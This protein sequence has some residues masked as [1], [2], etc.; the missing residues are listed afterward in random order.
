MTILGIETS[1]DETSAS[2]LRITDG[3]IEVLSNV[4]SS[5]IKLHAPFGG[6]VPALAAREHSQNLRPVVTEALS[7]AQ[8]EKPDLIAVT[9]G[10]GLISSLLVGS[11]FAQTLAWKYNIPI[12]GVNHMEGHVYSNWFSLSSLTEDVFPVVCLVVSGGHTQLILMKNHGEYE[13]LGQTRDD[14]AGEAFDKIARILG[15]G[16]PGGPALSKEAEKYNPEDTTD[17]ELPRPMI[18]SGNFEFSFSGLKTSVLYLIRDLQKAEKNIGQLA[19][20][21]AHEAQNA[22]VETLVT[23]TMKAALGHNAKTI[24][25]AGG[26]SAN[27]LLREELAKKAEQK[28]IAYVQPKME[29]TTDNAAMIALAGYFNYQKNPS[30]EWREVKANANW[31][32]V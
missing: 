17:I 32:I 16:Y 15:L 21:I 24:M 26:V 9:S 12:L 1:C 11:T 22:I 27:T 3:Q 28:G 4:V 19:P 25:L 20:E 7:K 6:V 5:Q 14:A 30:T 10:P 8:I 29:F 23:K 31:E 18:H 2:V 13:L